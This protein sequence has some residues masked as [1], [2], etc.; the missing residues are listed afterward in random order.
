VMVLKMVVLPE[1]GF[2]AKAMV[3][4]CGDMGWKNPS[5]KE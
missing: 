1:L 5:C 2:P 4:A 3:K